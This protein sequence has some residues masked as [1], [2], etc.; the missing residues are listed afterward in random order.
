[1][2]TT[3]KEIKD[4]NIRYHDLAAASYD[5]KWGIDFDS[6]GMEQTTAKMRRALGYTPRRF[7]NALEIGAGTGYFSLN[8][9]QA[10]VIG[11]L[12]ATDISPGMVKIL[13]KNANRI[14]VPVETAVC[15][16]SELPFESNSFDLVL[17]HAILHHLPNLNRC[18]K[19]FYRVLKPGGTIVFCGEPS[20]VGDRIAAVPKK[21]GATLGPAWRVAVQAK[22]REEKRRGRSSKEIDHLEQFV[23]VHAFT[24]GQVEELANRAGFQQVRVTGEELVANVFGWL[25]RSLEASADP[26]SIPYAWRQFAFRWYMA[27][28][29]IDQAALE[30]RLP[31][32]IFYNLLI[33]AK[34]P[35]RRRR[36]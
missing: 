20:A 30:D 26:E 11:N 4:V 25:A 17:G 9:T 32:S 1:M 8:L 15:E 16:A 13:E 29:K 5:S 34:K 6:V 2:A 10:G 31:A 22:P 19:E 23:D 28:Q 33:S 21:V 24:P 12:T 3:P 35:A 36:K 7:K 14:A 18:F 27:L